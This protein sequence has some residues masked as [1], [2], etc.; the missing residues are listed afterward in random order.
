MY[1]GECGDYRGCEVGQEEERG[2]GC[3][4]QSMCEHLVVGMSF[5]FFAHVGISESDVEV[6]I[7][8]PTVDAVTVAD[9]AVADVAVAA[10][11]DAVTTVTAPIVSPTT[12]TTPAAARLP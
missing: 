7:P 6:A 12:P 1:V 3:D 2:H 10:V 5:V 8:T 9:V 4:Q 11:A